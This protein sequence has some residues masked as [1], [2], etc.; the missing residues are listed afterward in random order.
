M[1]MMNGQ[2]VAMQQQLQTMQERN[3]QLETQYNIL[4]NEFMGMT[5]SVLNHDHV[6]QQVMGYLNTVD[7]QRRRDSRI[8]T[9]FP[10]NAQQE[11]QA[12][13]QHQ[14]QPPPP[15][16]DDTPASPL[17]NAAKLMSENHVEALIN[18]KNLEQMNQ[19]SLRA[20]NGT[21]TT[22]PP[23]FFAH[24]NGRPS[25]R[26]APNSATSST[27]LRF[28]NI[29]NLVYP[30]GINNG[31][32]PMYSEHIHNIPYAMPVKPPEQPEPAAQPQQPPTGAA[33]VRK[34]STHVDP[35]WIRQPQILLVEDDPT[36]RRIG[37]KFLYAFNCSIDSSVSYAIS[38]RLGVQKLICLSLTVWKL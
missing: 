5:K 9:P 24:A 38:L 31:I 7:A 26:S 11:G 16:E 25:S 36:C 27:S 17:L 18:P 21:L 4:L 12:N 8:V 15:E 22:P 2:L 29:E 19:M 33:A 10:G 28:D 1:D 35:G 20:A 6:L 14:P 32:D 34:K 3:Y 37:G 23:E 13:T 30:V